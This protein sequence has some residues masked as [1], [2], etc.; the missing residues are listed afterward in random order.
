[1]TLYC[2]AILG[3]CIAQKKMAGS[4]PGSEMLTTLNH[5]R[6]TRSWNIRS[7]WANGDWHSID[8][9]MSPNNVKGP[10]CRVLPNI[11][12]LFPRSNSKTMREAFHAPVV[13]GGYDDIQDGGRKLIPTTHHR[14]MKS[15]LI[16]THCQL[17][18]RVWWPS[19]SNSTYKINFADTLNMFDCG[20]IALPHLNTKI[21]VISDIRYRAP[22]YNR[23]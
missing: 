1:M 7:T 4:S 12:N 18:V 20:T 5:L 14:S 17:L 9:G 8:S 2:T 10:I 21:S 23:N 13:G 15:S 3:C 6:V 16:T 19:M 22:H 11:S